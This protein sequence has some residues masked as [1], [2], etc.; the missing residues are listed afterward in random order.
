MY[1]L[2]PAEKTQDV[3]NVSSQ[4]TSLE[5]QYPRFLSRTGH[6]GFSP[7]HVPKFQNHRS[8]TDISIKHFVCTN[9]LGT[10]SYSYSYQ[11]GCGLSA[12]F[13]DANKDQCWL[14]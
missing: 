4:E 13:S 8:K 7:Q 1:A 11:L 3:C 12:K 9:N 2:S 14:F 10:L 5:T 6:V